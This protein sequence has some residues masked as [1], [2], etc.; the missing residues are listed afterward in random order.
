MK[1]RGNGTSQNC[2][3]YPHPIVT[4]I[5]FNGKCDFQYLISVTSKDMQSGDAIHAFNL[6]NQDSSA[7][8]QNSTLAGN[9]LI[10]Q[11]SDFICNS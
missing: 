4:C 11:S 5:K 10:G 1:V 8:R 7:S 6:N 2:N 3:L 9:K